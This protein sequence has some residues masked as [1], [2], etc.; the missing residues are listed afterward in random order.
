MTLRDFSISPHKTG[1]RWRP[2]MAPLHTQSNLIFS[3][4]IQ[5]IKKASKTSPN[6]VFLH[7]FA[8]QDYW[9]AIFDFCPVLVKNHNC[10]LS[11]I[12]D[13]LDQ[14]S[15]HVAAKSQCVP[16]M[17]CSYLLLVSWFFTRAFI[18]VVKVESLVSR[19]Y[20]WISI[21]VFTIRLS[22]GRANYKW[23]N[24]SL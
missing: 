17:I 18:L 16:P 23:K 20:H 21:A 13:N 19:Y 5:Q 10:K 4:T 8:Y 6:L 14:T 7:G 24:R 9:L 1:G 22:T 2:T 11:C 15:G 3:C 12:G